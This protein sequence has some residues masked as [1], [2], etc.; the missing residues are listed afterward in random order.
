[1]V[2][3][4]QVL[5]TLFLNKEFIELLNWN[6]RIWDME[7]VYEIQHLSLEVIGICYLNFKQL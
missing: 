5:F 4:T 6:W 7:T 2:S 1:M 3:L